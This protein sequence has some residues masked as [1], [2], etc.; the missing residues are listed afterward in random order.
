MGKK[1]KKKPT[2]SCKNC[3]D[4]F[5]VGTPWQLFCSSQCRNEWHSD[6]RKRAMALLDEEEKNV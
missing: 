4:E 6:R 1:P 5:D 2:K 3:K